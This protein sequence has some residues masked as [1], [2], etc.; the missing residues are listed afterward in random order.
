MIRLLLLLFIFSSLIYQCIGIGNIDKLENQ[1]SAI[2]SKYE[3]C[4][5][6]SDNANYTLI[7]ALKRQCSFNDPSR[8]QHVPPTIS[9]NQKLS[10]SLTNDLYSVCSLGYDIDDTWDLKKEKLASMAHDKNLCRVRSLSERSTLRTHWNEKSDVSKLNHYM[11]SITELFPV[12]NARNIHKIILF[13][14]SITAQIVK[15]LACDMLRT[16][17]ISVLNNSTLFFRTKKSEGEAIDVEYRGM[18][19]RLLLSE[20]EG[21]CV[22]S[23]GSKNRKPSVYQQMLN[24]FRCATSDATSESPVVFIYNAGLHLYSGTKM[25]KLYVHPI[26]KAFLAFA[27]ESQGRVFVLFRE[28]SSQ[29]FSA[30]D[31]GNY[32]GPI[33]KS[34]RTNDLCCIQSDSSIRLAHEYNWRNK[35]FHDTFTR[36][37]PDWTS[38]VAWIPFFNTSLKLYDMHTEA[39]KQ[40]VFDC[41]HYIY[42]PFILGPL[43]V[44]T[45]KA[46]K[47]ILTNK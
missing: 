33:A 31:G 16:S 12:L 45:V 11:N 41:T 36:E 38:Y 43:W 4:I 42:A 20:H 2:Y 28:T 35:V 47:T 14:D 13:G 1:S 22:G 25:F 8:L 46:I 44:D 21:D 3:Q 7:D 18:S 30:R 27:K 17:D 15:F 24:S 10:S 39:N 34:F 23:G 40:G 9:N 32:D 26:I 5:L 6:G 37:D 19:L 29:H